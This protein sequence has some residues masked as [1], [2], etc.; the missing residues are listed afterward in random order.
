MQS[1]TPPTANSNGGS[2]IRG[3]FRFIKFY[4]I[5]LI[6]AVSA[7]LLVIAIYDQV[8]PESK[9]YERFFVRQPLTKNTSKP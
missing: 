5:A 3:Y 7:I 1:A 4:F 2:F 6:L 9:V 8:S